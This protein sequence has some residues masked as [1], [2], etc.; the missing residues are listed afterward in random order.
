MPLPFIKGGERERERV[1][2]RERERESERE[3]E[4]EREKGRERERER[5]REMW[6][7]IDPPFD[8][9]SAPLGSENIFQTYRQLCSIN[10]NG[11]FDP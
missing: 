5:E 6:L 4:R 10:R 7:S 2:E 11:L 3:R 9:N 1:R 8:I